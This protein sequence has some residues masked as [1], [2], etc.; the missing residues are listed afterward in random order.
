MPATPTPPPHAWVTYP[1]VLGRHA[2]HGRYP[3]PLGG[4]VWWEGEYEHTRDPRC[5]KGVATQR[6]LSLHTSHTRA[7]CLGNTPRTA[8]HTSQALP[9]Q[10]TTFPTVPYG[11]GRVGDRAISATPTHTHTCTLRYFGTSSSTPHAH[12]PPL[13]LVFMRSTH[14]K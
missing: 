7:T 14:T 10:I 5:G 9:L 3:A 13:S 8:P 6:A 12:T 11:G 1:F 4:R 2:Y